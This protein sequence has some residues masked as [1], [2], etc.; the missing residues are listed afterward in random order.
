M[1]G[2]GQADR[3]TGTQ[4]TGVRQFTVKSSSSSSNV[5]FSFFLISEADRFLSFPT[6]PCALIDLNFF[7]F[8]G[9]AKRKE[10][11]RKELPFSPPP[12]MCTV[13]T[14]EV[15]SRQPPCVCVFCV[16]P[17]L[18]YPSLPFRASTPLLAACASIGATTNRP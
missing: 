12:P 2:A 5:R 9:G 17:C 11:Q 1:P 13:C 10:R 18:G 14:Y 3:Q 16:F 8:L 6:N 7:F 15:C 4:R